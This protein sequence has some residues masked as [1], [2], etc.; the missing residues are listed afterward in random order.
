MDTDMAVDGV[1]GPERETGLPL[2][3]GDSAST[4]THLVRNIR[5]AERAVLDRYP[6]L[7]HADGIALFVLVVASSTM[8]LST[9]LYAY[10]LLPAPMVVVLNALCASLLHEIEH[11]LIHRLY[12]R[13]RKWLHHATM[14]LVWI[15]R[16]NLVHGWYRRRMHLH[17]HRVSGSG[18]DLEERLLGLGMPWG[19]KRVLITLDGAWS[20]FLNAPTL[21]REVPGFRRRE[22]FWASLPVFPLYAAAL[23]GYPVLLLVSPESEIL[24]PAQVLDELLL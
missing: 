2:E 19:V 18:V 7:S 16:A 24:R 8:V 20:Y 14:A 13:T 9:T 10:G 22:L 12:F 17:H 5:A 21:E 6:I 11:D 15:L 3:A 23:T 1:R 4:A